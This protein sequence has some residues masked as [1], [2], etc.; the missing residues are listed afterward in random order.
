M[1]ISE[2]LFESVFTAYLDNADYD[3]PPDVSKCRGFIAAC[4]KLLAFPS[5]ASQNSVDTEFDKN[6]IR[7]QLKRAEQWLAANPT[8]SS[9][10]PTGSVLRFNLEDRT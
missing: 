4:R 9:T 1:P 6:A 7:E 10:T 5:R 3:L 2:A 8:T